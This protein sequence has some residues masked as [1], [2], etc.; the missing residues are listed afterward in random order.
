MPIGRAQKQCLYGLRSGFSSLAGN[1]HGRFL[2]EGILQLFEFFFPCLHPSTPD[3]LLLSVFLRIR[4][5]RIVIE[6]K[7]LFTQ[8]IKIVVG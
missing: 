6:L 3:F 4:R 7:F 1:Q 8:N 2:V 5:E